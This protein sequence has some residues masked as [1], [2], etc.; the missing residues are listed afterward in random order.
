MALRV[1]KPWDHIARF[2]Q[3]ECNPSFQLWKNYLV[4]AASD[5]PFEWS[6]DN[7]LGMCTDTMLPK[8][9]AV[10]MCFRACSRK[11]FLVAMI[12]HYS[13]VV[14]SFRET[15]NV[16]MDRSFGQVATK[17][18]LKEGSIRCLVN[19]FQWLFCKEH[20]LNPNSWS[21]YFLG[22]EVFVDGW[23]VFTVTWWRSRLGSQADY[24]NYLQW[25]HQ[26]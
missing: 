26:L 11:H 2:K 15:S 18:V 23:V 17:S 19:L 14:R 10:L 7:I 24:R 6:D 1:M 25:T 3:L 5:E 4:T 20:N 8:R 12:A 16:G 9:N 21:C 13:S 22:H